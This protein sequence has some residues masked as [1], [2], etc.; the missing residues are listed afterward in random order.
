[1]RGAMHTRRHTAPRFL[2]LAGRQGDRQLHADGSSHL[3]PTSLTQIWTERFAQSQS[4]S[5]AVR[6]DQKPG[7]R[8]VE[9]DPG[10]ARF[11][12]V[13]TYGGTQARKCARA[14][15][16][17]RVS[18]RGPGHRSD[19]RSKDHHGGARDRGAEG[20][21]RALIR[22]ACSPSA[23]EV[24]GAL[25]LIGAERNDSA[26]ECPSRSAPPCGRNYRPV[27]GASRCRSSNGIRS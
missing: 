22:G 2:R 8:A 1:M 4:Q 16:A 17:P 13:C 26:V 7:S 27:G 11:G 10:F 14:P 18:Q 20:N 6:S 23:G 9:R 3:P 24:R 15:P 21:R 25:S 5:R 12:G 19:S